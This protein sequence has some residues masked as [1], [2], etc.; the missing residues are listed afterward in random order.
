MNKSMSDRSRL[1][2][3][4]NMVSFALNDI[5][6]YLDTHPDDTEALEYFYHYQDIR[7]Q[8]LKEYAICYGP[9]T[10]DSDTKRSDWDWALQPF[11]WEGGHC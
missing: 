5:T 8:A 11:P 2:H 1:S 3:W 10:L 9:L 6:L 7:N 4:I